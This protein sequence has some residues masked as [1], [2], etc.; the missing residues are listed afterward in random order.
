MRPEG[1]YTILRKVLGR[2]TTDSQSAAELGAVATEP[3]S[4]SAAEGSEAVEA[5]LPQNNRRRGPRIS[6]KEVSRLMGE[7]AH[8]KAAEVTSR[9]RPRNPQ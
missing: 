9:L 6:P 3:S 2:R 1:L 4:T 8:Q 7:S 5:R